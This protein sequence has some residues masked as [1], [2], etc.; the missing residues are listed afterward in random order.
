[1]KKILFLVNVDWFF[2]SHRLPIAL[3][4]QK[5]GYEVHVAC[6]FSSH[7]DFLSSCGFNLHSISFDRSGAGFLYELRTLFSI[8]RL[9]KLVAPDLV[10]AVTIKP[11]LYGGVAARLT[12]VKSMA[13]A[14]SGLGLVFVADGAMAKARRWFISQFYQF[15][16]NINN[17]KVIFQNPEDKKILQRM[18]RLP[19]RRSEMIRG[20]GVDLS[21]Y[22]VEPEP[23]KISV[24][25]AARLLKDKGVYQFI[26][27]ARILRKRGIPVLFKLVGTPDFGNPNT[28]TNEELTFWCNEG[29]VEL[30]G[31][32]EDIHRVFADSN[33]VVLPSFYGE[34]LPKVLMEAAACGRA[35]V[36]TDNPGCV[37]A[38]EPGVTAL[39]VPVKDSIA[40]AEAIA[41]LISD[42]ARRKRMA[43][44]GRRLAEEAF[45]I[46]KVVEQ[47]MDIYRD[48]IHP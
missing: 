9:F 44:A 22:S 47:H 5:E 29:T 28:V 2:V 15:A 31:F 42:P 36:T 37:A 25:M 10:H 32:R 33:I 16:L 3:Q 20:S 24:V 30:L 23:N 6:K 14:I 19:D 41:T 39:I 48:L 17:S 35:V 4:A 11:V 18:L 34:G 1:M 7:Y 12:G 8:R 27:A 43:N 45:T 38:T 40:L 26:D 21:V 13:F 46:E